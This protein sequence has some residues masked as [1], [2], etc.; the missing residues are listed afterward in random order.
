MIGV[1]E[2]TTPAPVLRP[3]PPLVRRGH[4]GRPTIPVLVKDV[5]TSPPVTVEPT[6]TVKDIAH[7]LLQHDIRCVPVVDIGD[8]L[9]GIVSEADLVCREGYP[10]ARSHH[11]AALIDEAA[12]ERRHH[13]TA[14]AAGLTAGEIMTTAVITCAPTEPVAVVVRRMLRHNVRTLPVIDDRRLAGVLSRHDILPL[15]DR[16]DREIRV[17]VTEM[18]ADPLWAPDGHAIEAEVLDGVVVLTGSVRHPSDETVV[19]NLVRQV[20]GV[21]EVVDHLTPQGAEPTPAYLHDTDWR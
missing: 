9:V 6:A 15:F 20:P 18:L 3:A 19:C 10:T 12:A 1:M 4:P 17:S 13:W 11:L 8:T 7:V 5:M 21:I 14:R 2:E 16:P